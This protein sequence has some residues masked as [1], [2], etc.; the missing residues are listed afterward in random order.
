MNENKFYLKKADW[1]VRLIGEGGGTPHHVELQTEWNGDSCA[2]KLIN[3][4]DKDYNVK[5]IVLF[6]RDLPFDVSTPVY[7]EGYSKLSQYVGTIDTVST[8]TG[9][10]DHGHYKIPQAEDF[11]TVYNLALFSPKDADHILMAFTSCHRFNGEIRFGQGTIEIVLVTDGVRLESGQTWQLEDFILVQGPDHNTLFKQIAEAIRIHH[12]LLQVEETPT[13]WCSW[14]WYG[15]QVKEENILAN[16]DEM[17]TEYP[18]LKYV[19]IDDG[20]QAYMGDWLTPGPA[21]KDMKKL[22]RSILEKGLE[23]AIWV[24]PFIAEKDSNLFKNHPNWFIKDA[25][26]NPLP[27]DIVSFGGW[28][29]GPW[30]MLDGT[31]PDAQN[32]LTHVFR[33]MREDWGSKYFK[34]DANMWGALHGGTYY[35]P[36]TTRVEAYREGMK[37]VLQGAGVDSFVLGCNAPMWPSLGVVHGMRVSDDFSRTWEKFNKNA[38][39]IFWRNWQHNQ[40]WVNDPDCVLLENKSSEQIGPDGKVITTNNGL[41][42]DEFLFHA[43]SIYCSGGMVLS[44]D[45]L[46]E[47]SEKTKSRLRKL[48]KPTDVPAQFVDNGFKVGRIDLG[49]Q[50]LV[51]VFN[52]VDEPATLEVS[53]PQSCLIRDFWTDEELGFYS[54]KITVELRPHHARLYVCDTKGIQS[55]HIN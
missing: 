54:E 10:C 17:S 33:T 12:P 16:M 14:Y 20:Y 48:L 2:S 7:G 50:Q 4:G 51:A 40:L 21:F 15:P 13:G 49:H 45:N 18:E 43:T 34:L 46:M 22:C 53:L 19:Q 32:Y 29:N 36:N 24:A 42:D 3:R 8:I 5:E 26:G 38:T 37:A 9:Y 47:H 41:T 30:Y 6:Q 27:S 39:E 11:Q 35:K 55:D 31:H 52:R 23:P 25:S 44:G 1:A 28:R